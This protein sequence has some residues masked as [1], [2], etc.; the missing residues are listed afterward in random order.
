[1][2]PKI[3][4]HHRHEIKITFCEEALGGDGEEWENFSM[5]DMGMLLKAVRKK[6]GVHYM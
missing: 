3:L 4:N 5:R 1:M 2:L 6:L